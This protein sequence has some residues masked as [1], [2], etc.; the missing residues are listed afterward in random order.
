LEGYTFIN[1]YDIC[2][3][4]GKKFCKLKKGHSSYAPFL[5]NFIFAFFTYKVTDYDSHP[6]HKPLLNDNI[7]QQ[8]PA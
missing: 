3:I 7:F 5:T 4:C 2:N 8:I 6:Y 1:A